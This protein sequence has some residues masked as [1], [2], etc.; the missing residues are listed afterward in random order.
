MAKPLHK[1]HLPDLRYVLKVLQGAH[2]Q[3][4]QRGDVQAAITGMRYI[5]KR[6]EEAAAH[7]APAQEV[8]G[9]RAPW[10]DHLGQPIH[11][12]DR[13]SHPNGHEFT[14]VRLN[15][16]AQETDAWRAIY[17]DCSVSRLCLQI[18]D[19]GQAFLSE[20]ISTP[21]SAM[22]VLSAIVNSDVGRSV[23]AKLAEGQGTDTADGRAWAR[24][25]SLVAA[26]KD[27]TS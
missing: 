15:G 23:L 24:A 11:H 4:H 3:E 12:G 10:P 27:K 22:E 26:N 16:H 17:D 8:R 9:V 1:N 7:T 2:V 20:G 25:R 21:A 6:T 5:I 18:G 19:K 13:L 14:A